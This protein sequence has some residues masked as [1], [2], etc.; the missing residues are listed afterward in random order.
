M[1]KCNDSLG[2]F[3]DGPSLQVDHPEFGNQ[4]HH[5]R[6]RRRHD[7]AGS[8]VKHDP[9]AALTSLF[10]GRREADKRL[11][12]FR[13]VGAAHKLQLASGAADVAVAVGFRSYLS[14][15]I[16]LG[17]V[18][19]GHYFLVLHDDVRRVRVIHLVAVQVRVAVDCR[20]KGVQ[21]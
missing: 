9:A 13:C 19:N 8:K 6:A 7:I 5:V 14:L 18:V 11:T 20:V 17:G 12:S 10:I 3:R 2:A 21:A 16:D 4:I 1:R 15:Q